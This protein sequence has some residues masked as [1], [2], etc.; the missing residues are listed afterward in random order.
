MGMDLWAC[1][2]RHAFM[3]MHS[4]NAFISMHSWACFYG[5]SWACIQWHRFIGMHSWACIEERGFKGIHSW[6]CIHRHAFM[7]MH[8][9]ACF[10]GQSW[11][12]IHGHALKSVDQEHSFMGNGHAFMGMHSWASIIYMITIVLHARP[13]V[14]RVHACSSIVFSGHRRSSA[15][16]RVHRSTRFTLNRSYSNR[17]P[18]MPPVLM[19][20]MSEVIISS[21][22]RSRRSL[23]KVR[24]STASE[25]ISK[26]PD[27]RLPTG[28]QPRR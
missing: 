20:V 24:P 11:A 7:G 2:H 8:S 1:I 5:Q 21:W 6:A 25:R 13:V 18:A 26:S 22:R 28:R 17:H 4:W 16:P 19:T 27:D 14:S 12:C 10:H 3:G 9:W 23:V 15:A